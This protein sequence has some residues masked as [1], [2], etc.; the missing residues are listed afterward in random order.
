MFCLNPVDVL[1]TY[2]DTRLFSGRDFIPNTIMGI[3]VAEFTFANFWDFYFITPV[4]LACKIPQL[5]VRHH[6]PAQ[7]Y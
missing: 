1:I 5:S 4:F 3:Y 6:L 7:I 2:V